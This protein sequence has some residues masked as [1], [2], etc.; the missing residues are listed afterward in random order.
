MTVDWSLKA[1][2]GAT[3]RILDD[4]S[5]NM[6]HKSTLIHGWRLTLRALIGDLSWHRCSGVD[7][8]GY[9]AYV[10][11]EG[12]DLQWLKWVSFT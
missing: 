9:P 6:L 11:F 7:R 5:R 12:D 1:V 10:V 2:R 4:I 8:G 3:T